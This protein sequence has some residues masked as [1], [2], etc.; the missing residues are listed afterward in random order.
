MNGVT[1]KLS[2]DP[3]LKR[4][5]FIQC[6]FTSW[7]RILT[8][9]HPTHYAGS[10]LTSIHPTIQPS[11]CPPNYTT[12]NRPSFCPSLC[13]PTNPHK[14]V[15]L[16]APQLSPPATRPFDSC[17]LGACFTPGTRAGARVKASKKQ[18]P[19]LPSL[20]EE[21]FVRVSGLEP[22]TAHGAFRGA[23]MGVRQGC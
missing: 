16:Q 9:L 23:V 2:E 22:G 15:S 1:T 21:S 5:S 8:E 18:G 4:T 19:S 20:G 7:N 3:T 10:T 12:M 14:R 6:I 13:P 17:R 11:T